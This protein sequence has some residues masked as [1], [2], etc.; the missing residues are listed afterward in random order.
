MFSI[1]TSSS[2]I[3]GER[4]IWKEYRC[5]CCDWRLGTKC[6]AS[7]KL[8]RCSTIGQSPGSSIVRQKRFKKKKAFRYWLLGLTCSNLTFVLKHH[9]ISRE[10]ELAPNTLPNTHSHAHA[11][12]RT[13]TQVLRKWIASRFGTWAIHLYTRNSYEFHVSLSRK[14]F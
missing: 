14:E 3:W 9:G 12:A 2:L 11:C 1:L 8:G 13:H 10:R 5:M 4:G 6:R 7:C